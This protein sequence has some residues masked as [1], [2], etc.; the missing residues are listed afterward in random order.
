MQASRFEDYNHN[1]CYLGVTH[2]KC[3]EGL[4]N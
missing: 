3:L 2:A 1:S 4:R